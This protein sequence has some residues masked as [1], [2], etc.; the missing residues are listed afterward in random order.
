MTANKHYLTAAM[1][2]LTDPLSC[3]LPLTLLVAASS[4]RL[5]CV[6]RDVVMLVQWQRGGSVRERP[7]GVDRGAG[8][9][10]PGPAPSFLLL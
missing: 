8:G 10:T 1:A 9:G 6:V 3:T 7:V 4:S 2:A 5:A